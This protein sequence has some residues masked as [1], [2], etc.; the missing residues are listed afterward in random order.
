MNRPLPPWEFGNAP[1]DETRR[2][3]AIARRIISLVLQME[4]P[5]AEVAEL[6]ET[7][8]GAEAG[9]AALT[10]G[11][12]R[13]RVGAATDADGRVYLDHSRN[14]GD[15]DPAFPVY[16]ISVAGDRATGTV[17]FPPLYEGPPGL[18]HGGFLALLFDQ[19]IQH[20]NCDVG[21]TGKTI[22]L[23]VRYSA[24]TP[25]LAELRF[26]IE[27]TLEG[28]RIESTARLFHGETLC[29]TATMR[30]VAGDRDALPPVSPRRER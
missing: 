12:P 13:P 27:R 5:S 25:L 22:G 24:P 10:P 2:F 17:R 9:L 4:A 26:E 14:I 30:A 1:L 7:L 23:E 16:E 11:D 15:Y 3:T 20:H 6:A 18:V 19:I 21:Q 8:E 28:R 29:A